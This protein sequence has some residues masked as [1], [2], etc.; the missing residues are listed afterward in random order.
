MAETYRV[1][2]ITPEDY[3]KAMP[4]LSVFQAEEVK[5]IREQA[6]EELDTMSK[7]DLEALLEY[8]DSKRVSRRL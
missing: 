4:K 6:K 3:R 7:D 8:I 5:D 2:Y 1:G